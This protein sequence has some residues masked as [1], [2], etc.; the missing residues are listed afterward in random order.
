MLAEQRAVILYC[1]RIE[2]RIELGVIETKDAHK[3]LE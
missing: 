2:I 3:S 1:D